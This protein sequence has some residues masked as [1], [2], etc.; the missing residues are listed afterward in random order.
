MI[1]SFG[2]DHVNS[3]SIYEGVKVQTLLTSIEVL[4]NT[5]NC[6]VN[7]YAEIEVCNKNPLL[8]S[9]IDQDN[10]NI[11]FNDDKNKKITDFRSISEDKSKLKD[12]QILIEKPV[13]K[14]IEVID[15]GECQDFDPVFD[16]KLGKNVYKQFTYDNCRIGSHYEYEAVKEYVPFDE[17][18]NSKLLKNT[19]YKIRIE[20][21]K[22][23]EESIDWKIKL[24]SLEPDWAWWNSTFL[25]RYPIYNNHTETEYSLSVNDTGLVGNREIIWASLIN[26]SYIYCQNSGCT[27]GMIAIANDTDEKNWENETTMSGFN[28]YGVWS[29]GY[30]AVYHLEQ[31]A[32]NDSTVMSS[33]GT[34]GGT[35][36]VVNGLFGNGVEFAGGSDYIDIDN[37]VNYITDHGDFSVEFWVKPTRIWDGDV[38]VM[39]LG[40]HAGGRADISYD[41]GYGTCN[42][43]S[44]C[45]VAYDGASEHIIKYTT[46]FNQDQWYYVVFTFDTD[47]NECKIYIDGELKATEGSFDWE[48]HGTDRAS[49]GGGYA[50]TNPS[51]GVF[52][53]YRFSNVTRDL[54]YI[55]TNYYNGLGNMTTLGGEEINFT[56]YP[57]FYNI[58]EPT[59]PSPY[60]HYSEAAPSYNFNSTINLTIGYVDTVFFEFNDTTGTL[61]DMLNYTVSNTSSLYFKEF[62]FSLPAGTY[63]YKFHANETLDGEW[64]STDYYT[65]TISKTTITCDTKLNGTDGFTYLPTNQSYVFNLSTSGGYLGQDMNITSNITLFTNTSGFGTLLSE[66]NI[67]LSEGSFYVNGSS[68]ST[69]NNTGCSDTEYAVVMPSNYTGHSETYL[70]NVSEKSVENFEIVINETYLYDVN[71]TF[72]YNGTSYSVSKSKT[73]YGATDQYTFN[74]SMII[75]EVNNVSET[76]SFNFTMDYYWYNGTSLTAGT[77]HDQTINKFYVSNCTTG[78][79]AM[80]IRIYNETDASLM[81]GTLEVVFN[82][83]K[84]AELLIRNYSFLFEGNDTYNICIYPG[85]ENYSMDAFMEVRDLP[86]YPRRHHWIFNETLTN[87]T[88][89]YVDLYLLNDTY[90]TFVSILVQND[91][92]QGEED[93]LVQTQKYYISNNSYIEVAEGL[94]NYDGI[95]NTYLQLNDIYYKFILK[96]K[97]GTILRSFDPFLVTSNEITLPISEDPIGEWFNY[98]DETTAGCSFNNATNIL[99][100]TFSDTSGTTT[101]YCL[102]VREI[103]I[104]TNTTICSSN[105]NCV[106]TASGSLVCD[107]VNSTDRVFQY[108]LYREG[109]GIKSPLINN[110]IDYAN[111]ASVYSLAGVF[112]AMIL[113]LVMTGSGSWNP[114][115]S[116]TLGVVAIIISGLMGFLSIGVGSMI[117]LGF[118]VGIVLYLMRTR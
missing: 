15:Y 111:T 100:C 66:E 98:N 33:K 48:F 16:E 20:G 99:T 2:I 83:W 56:Y 82:L 63:I 14:Q 36:T 57:I 1:L 37:I 84:D 47:T 95:A 86:Q 110:I 106:S 101:E 64:N 9:T 40:T 26:D 90:A 72:Y 5:D 77:S 28:P 109:G 50:G 107:L 115:V 42:S 108:V 62:D 25:Y 58:Q 74:K 102:G 19:C 53:E 32:A 61:T 87:A 39:Y 3:A 8:D 78:D 114:A 96:E 17:I 31:T 112:G 79:I 13:V 38:G 6:L 68:P 44:I 30:A 118:I 71:A 22:E 91:A 73:T 59:D 97:D 24:F 65:W 89:S 75:P 54:N 49:M 94:T 4:D 76:V 92:G 23:P 12:F 113:F 117:G 55:Q 34:A 10:F 103:G 52:D 69:Q 7:C 46:D 80:T 11:W 18:E 104:M 67:I 27:S 29:N 93:I 21:T 41:A 116:L 105:T 51:Y 43:G 35:P 85:Y 88:R 45:M 60:T 81:N 70:A